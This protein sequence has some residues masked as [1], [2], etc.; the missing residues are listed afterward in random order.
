MSLPGLNLPRIEGNSRLL[1][2]LMGA[3]LAINTAMAGVRMAAPLQALQTGHAAWSVG[4]LLALF[5]LL[6]ILTAMPTGRMTDRWGYHRPLRLAVGL[7]VAGSAMA[8]L[9]VHLPGAWQYTTL[10][11]GAAAAGAGANMCGIATQRSGG[12]LATDAR[13]RLRIFSWLAMAPSLASAVGPV[14]AGILID[15]AGYGWAY[16]L[17]ATLPLL[18]LPLSRAL[19]AQTGRHAAAAAA[20]RGQ[21]GELLAVPGLKRLLF[22]N[23][24]LSASWDVHSFAVPV[25]GHA[26]GFSASTIGLVLGAF[27]L[28]VTAVRVVVPVLA[29]RVNEARLLIAAMLITALIFVF[30]PFAA[31]PWQMGLSAMLLGLAL[32]AVQPTVVASLYALSP[33]GRH[34]EVIAFRSMAISLS[35]TVMPLAFG[36]AGTLLGPGVMFWLMGAAV[37]AGSWVARGLRRS[38]APASAH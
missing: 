18:A 36:V 15:S 25:L 23:W 37:G 11:L 17:M 10:C 21:I 24:L 38:A 31:S 3:Q 5:S 30:Y 27:T 19:P 13:A 26:R 14:L 20:A 1:L 28:A 6:P 9:S 35:N 16:A 7:V 12:Q 4:L 32:G 33:V 8:L 29:H 34:G 22:V 2:S